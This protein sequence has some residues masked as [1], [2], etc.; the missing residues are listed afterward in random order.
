VAGAF[1]PSRSV[2][3]HRRQWHVDE[4]I[5]ILFR[6]RR[7]PRSI[8]PTGTAVDQHLGLERDSPLLHELQPDPRAGA[9]G[10]DH[11][12]VSATLAR[13][14]GIS[15]LRMIAIPS[16]RRACKLASV[17]RL[18]VRGKAVQTL[19]ASKA[20]AFRITRRTRATSSV[21]SLG[22]ESRLV[23]LQRPADHRGEAPYPWPA[24]AGHLHLEP[25]A[26]CKLQL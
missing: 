1:P 18:M 13:R 14:A 19:Q 11:L 4:Q 15:S 5:P 2:G 3:G 22:T 8:T 23:Q 21:A 9:P 10:S 6:L 20:R 16:L 17:T 25:F 12:A 26:R 7:G 24:N